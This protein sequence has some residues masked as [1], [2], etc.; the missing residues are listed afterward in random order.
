MQGKRRM[1]RNQAY[2][3]GERDAKTTIFK[4]GN[5]NIMVT[6]RQVGIKEHAD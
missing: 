3:E 1:V 5:E 2:E 6:E 4:A